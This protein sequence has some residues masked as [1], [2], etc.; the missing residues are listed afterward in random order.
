MEIPQ[1]GGDVSWN[2]GI[3]PAHI[4]KDLIE[5]VKD[6]II[7]ILNWGLIAPRGLC[8]EFRRVCELG[9]GKK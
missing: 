4:V 2:S 9:W 3:C 6:L 7:E 8:I 1:E 5:I